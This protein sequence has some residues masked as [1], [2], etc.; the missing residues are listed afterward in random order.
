[1]LVIIYLNRRINPECDGDFFRFAIGAMDDEHY[2]LAWT[3]CPAFKPCQVEDLC[4]IQLER[5]GVCALFEL[6]GQHAH[7]NQIATV[8]SL[9]ALRDDGLHTKQLCAF[10][11]PVARAS[12]AILLPGKDY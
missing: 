3:D 12:G 9:E 2:V 10:G 1:M 4:T 11:G 8:N 5:G 7:A 6:A